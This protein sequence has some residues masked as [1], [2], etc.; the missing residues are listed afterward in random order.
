MGN[1]PRPPGRPLPDSTPW[2]GGGF[3]VL[4][5]LGLALAGHVSGIAFLGGA[6]AA[7]LSVA[8]FAVVF[9]LASRLSHRIGAHLLLWATTVLY[10]VLVNLVAAAFGVDPIFAAG[11][12]AAT[13]FGVLAILAL[14]VAVG[15]G[16]VPT[17]VRSV[18]FVGLASGASYAVGPELWWVG[19]V[20]GSLLAITVAMTLAA[21]LERP[22]AAE[23]DFGT[24]RARGDGIGV[25]LEVK[26]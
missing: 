26:E 22:H 9:A 2:S 20:T 4:T 7:S 15:F 19:L 25:R 17:C 13:G 24:D 5:G 11:A 14:A 12:V 3:T 10:A 8:G 16:V 23:G 21:A 6:L 18:A 1:H